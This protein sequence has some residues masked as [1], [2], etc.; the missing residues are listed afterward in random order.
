MSLPC[1]GAALVLFLVK[2]DA[3]WLGCKL[4]VTETCDDQPRCGCPGDGRAGRR[5]HDNDCAAPAFPNRI[6]HVATTDA[7]V[8]DTQVTSVI[9]DEL[10]GK[11]LVLGTALPRFG[12]AQRGSAGQ[13]GRQAR[14]L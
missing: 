3:F 2:R 10:A 4:H 8:T 9:H 1:A 13:R 5:G 11:T 7:T 6:T 12:V 14:H